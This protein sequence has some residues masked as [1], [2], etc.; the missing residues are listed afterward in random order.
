[1]PRPDSAFIPI[2]DPAPQLAQLEDEL[3]AAAAR[4]IRSGGWVLGEE[5]AAFERAA[6]AYLGV[7]HAIGVN[8]GTDALTIA[9]AALGVGPGDEVIT[10]AF[11]FFGTAE[12]ISRLGAEPRFADIDPGDFNLRPDA[13]AA[14]IGPRTR[15]ILPVHLF[16]AAADMDALS[17]VAADAGVPLVE[18]VAQA[19]GACWNGRRVGG[20]G[21]LGAFSFYPTKN[22]GG[23]GDGG[24]VVTHDSDLAE[25][26]R[27]LR[28][29]GN[30]GDGTHTRI[31]FNSRLDALQAALLG[32]KLDYVDRWNDDRRRIA[33]RYHELL[34]GVV[35]VGR[36]APDTSERHV[37]HQ[38]T[39]RVPADC[40]DRV[41]TRLRLAGIGAT[42]YYPL[43]LHRQPPYRH[44]QQALPH[45]ERAATEVL[46]LPISPG[47]EESA[48][49]RI[50]AALGEILAEEMA[51]GACRAPNASAG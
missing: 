50:V 35:E 46:S 24:L 2:C 39:V 29:H 22:L 21:T 25:R 41:V 48:Q 43:P 1:M 38:Y 10:S 9:L 40:R 7:P 16:G 36:P 5:V 23:F 3:L 8:S 6:A 49:Q 11:T 13:V 28:N 27:Q 19:F 42:V 47:L 51:R 18:D 37:W 26:C 4:V 33:R 14:A 45:A 31:G 44:L 15:C 20:I 32:V 30:R 12:A 34:G 17:A